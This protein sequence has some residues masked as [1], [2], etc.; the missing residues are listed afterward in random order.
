MTA[1]ESPVEGKRVHL[2]PMVGTA[3][4]TGTLTPLE[5]LVA[6]LED[7]GSATRGGGNWTCPVPEHED[8]K[9]SLHVEV[10]RDGGAVLFCHAGCETVDVLN[11]VG[12]KKADL[13]STAT[14]TPAKKPTPAAIY[15]YTNGSGA[16]L[17]QV[18]R[19]ANKGKGFP[20][21]RWD[22]DS[23]RFVPGMDG[24]T[25]VLYHLP[26]LRVAIDA[27]DSTVYV[28]EG[29]KDVL[30]AEAE[31]LVATTASGGARA[32][33]DPSFT[34]SL[35][36]ATL[37]RVV[38]DRDPPGYAHA[39]KVQAALSDAGISCEVR[40][41]VPTDK[42]A[43]LTDHLDAGHGVDALILTTVDELL[44]LVA[45]D[46]GGKQAAATDDAPW[47]DTGNALRLLRAHGEDMRFIP[48]YKKW[49]A[50]DGSRWALDDDLAQR[51]AMGVA[52]ALRAR[53][54]EMREEGADEKSVAA[55]ARFG[56]GSG[57]IGKVRSMLDAA[58]A[59]KG[60][61]KPA[62]EWDA[63]PTL[64]VT[65]SGTVELRA[66]GARSRPSQRDDYATRTTDVA[67][68]PAA[69]APTWERFLATALPEVRVRADLQKLAGYTLLGENRERRLVFLMGPSS[70]GK[71]TFIE[72]FARAL[73]GYAT[74]YSLSLFREKPGDSPRPDLM[75]VL[76]SRLIYATEASS[77]QRLHADALKRMTGGDRISA[78]GMH[79]DDFVSRVP[80]FT[81]WV[82]SNQAPTVEGADPALFRRIFAVP[83]EN[84][85]PVGE[86]DVGL[87]D[88]S[89]RELPGILAWAVAGWDAYRATGLNDMAEGTVEATMSLREKL[90]SFDRFLK[91]CTESGAD[92]E[93]RF[94]EL[95][96]RY[97]SW[98]EAERL[99]LGD[100]LTSN[101][102]AARLDE[103]DYGTRRLRIPGHGDNKERFR[104]GLRLL[105][106]NGF[107]V[108]STVTR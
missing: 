50:W 21:F 84:V 102:F 63:D 4:A 65:R 6:A 25:R 34:E 29:E 103:R 36:G 86:E 106:G 88:R 83:F 80:A 16:P 95:F 64:L 98:A 40:L 54:E 81:P 77:D 107:V 60:M 74:D 76:P 51:W 57:N 33:W 66:D 27:G 53:A 87:R 47:N 90:S 26:A 15:D 104:T 31:G 99:P 52:D 79:S 7:R 75:R 46:A 22:A 100:R 108:R 68:D 5:K 32:K 82:V 91:D 101:A 49:A 39:E 3:D 85:I 59:M 41:P 67:Y 44:A 55:L 9:Q 97:V 72:I 2:A 37:V 48:G 73:G 70:T 78:R 35:N 19:T 8:A 30:M 28:V 23:G 58:K 11:A 10:G 94:G 1:D 45:G 61:S 12:L 18:K 105:S 13:F 56:I 38:A 71:S 43:D 69:I 42:G 17:Y 14:P 89:L 93:A 62:D 20:Q 24:V 92:Y 96:E